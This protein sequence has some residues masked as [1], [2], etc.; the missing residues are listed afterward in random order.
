[1]SEKITDIKDLPKFIDIVDDPSNENVQKLISDI[2]FYS[3]TFNVPEELLNALMCNAYY[4]GKISMFKSTQ[5]K[6]KEI[7]N[8]GKKEES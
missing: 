5:E 7:N 6:L 3:N 8:I 2:S 4:L 1:M